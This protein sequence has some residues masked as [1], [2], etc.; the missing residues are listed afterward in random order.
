MVEVYSV[1]WRQWEVNFG[2][3]SPLA[4]RFQ[5]VLC[6]TKSKVARWQ[7]LQDWIVTTQATDL[8]QHCF[9]DFWILIL[10][11]LCIYVGFTPCALNALPTDIQ[12]QS[13]KSG[14]RLGMIFC[15]TR[16]STWIENLVKSMPHTTLEICV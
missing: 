10:K 16:A 9:N 4:G 6:H 2:Q 12:A 8:W 3:H 11:W 13:H 7:H 14:T 15:I 5:G 1:S